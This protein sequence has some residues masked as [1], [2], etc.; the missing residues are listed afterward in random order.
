MTK[1]TEE[2]MEEHLKAAGVDQWGSMGG[3]GPRR[4]QAILRIA[5]S[6]K[7]VN[8]LLE[9]SVAQKQG[10]ITLLQEKLLRLKHGGGS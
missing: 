7:K 2:E 1:M 6:L 4:P 8:A 9:S 5:S 3:G 10:E